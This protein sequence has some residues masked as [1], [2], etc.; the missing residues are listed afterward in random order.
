MFQKTK[1]IINIFSI[2]TIVSG[3][4]FLANGFILAWT[5][6]TQA[7]PGANVSP[8]L[9][10]SITAQSKQG[11]L[12]IGANNAV[13]TGLVVQYGNV[14]IGTTG[15]GYN[16]HIED[17]GSTARP[18]MV[19]SGVGG[20]VA[21]L[22]GDVMS[23]ANNTGGALG[24]YDNGNLKVYLKGIGDSYFNSGNVGIGTTGPGA[25][26]DVQGG[27]IKV[28]GTYRIGSTD[29]GQYFIDSAGTDGQ[30]WKSDGSGR[31]VWG[32]AQAGG[33][34]DW[35]ISGNNMYSGV[36][37]NVGI[38]TSNVSFPLHIQKNNSGWLTAFQN[39]NT[40][41][42]SVYLANGNGYGAYIGAGTD[43]T[44]STYALRVT[45]SG[46]TYLNVTG[47]GNV[48]IGTT[49]PGA[50]LHVS[51]GD[52]YM[53][54]NNAK[55]RVGDGSYTYIA[56]Y[57]SSDTDK[58]EL[59]G[60]QGVIFTGSKNVGIGVTAPGAKLEV[61][62]QV[63]ITG[64]SPGAGK[65]LTSNAAGL[66]TWQT[67]PITCPCGTCWATEYYTISSYEAYYRMCTPAGWKQTSPSPGISPP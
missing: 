20:E 29:Y 46:G 37:G 35:I 57:S 12:V 10:T 40:G 43:S 39:T 33:D 28:S 24:L 47:A 1:Q 15:P 60:A 64:G 67:F 9:N 27:D 50:K 21:T 34:N 38:G 62:G 52:I 53:S 59:Y 18:R 5:A 41:G 22:L 13:T 19:I 49:A 3:C 63:K 48:G 17:T 56:D 31:G 65:V 32:A 55:L 66:A 23:D 61:A 45:G 2:L 25:K 16:L 7:P 36:S 26:L 4:I 14:G 42:G 30:V 51:G 44:A 6:P 11:A 54:S 58:L 8:P